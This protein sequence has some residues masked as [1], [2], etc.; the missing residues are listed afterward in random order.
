MIARLCHF[1]EDVLPL[2]QVL[3]AQ[4]LCLVE[5]TCAIRGAAPFSVSS[6]LITT[7]IF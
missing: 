3:V 4:V 2:V 5:P 1:S 6:K 7:P